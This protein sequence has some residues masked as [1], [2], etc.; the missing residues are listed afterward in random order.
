MTLFE[1]LSPLV[2]G[3]LLS[4]SFTLTPL[5][6]PSQLWNC[7]ASRLG[8]WT[9]SLAV[10]IRLLISSSFM[11]LKIVHVLMTPQLMSSL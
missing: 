5:A 7:D 2:S 11:V 3:I 10:A 1:S 8:P 4:S 9:S 6:A